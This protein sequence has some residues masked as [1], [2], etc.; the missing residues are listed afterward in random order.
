MLYRALRE[1]ARLALRWHYGEL[2]VQGTERIPAT[3][4]LLIVANHPNALVDAL[5][6]AITVRRRV[7]LTAK[8]TLFEHSVLAPLLRAVGVVPL[9][10]AKDERAAARGVAP[11]RNNDAFRLV[12][13]ALA[14][15]RAV[16][17]FPEGVSHDEPALAP[18][19]TGAARMAF[20]AR[21]S[22]T[23]GV[24]I[25]PV[26]LIFEEKERPR[27]RVLVRVGEPLDVD[28]WTHA[29][30]RESVAALTDEITERLRHVTLNFP[31]EDRARRA[32]RIARA[33]ATMADD[34]AS[35]A[36][37][38]SLATEALIAT[39]VEAVTTVLDAAPGAMTAR[40]DAFIA[41]LDLLEQRLA[42]RGANLLDAKISTRIRHGAR[43]VVREATLTAVAL[44]VAVLGWATHWL[45]IRFARAAAIRSLGGDASRDQPAMRTIIVGLAIVLVWYAAQAALVAWS[46]GGWVATAWIIIIYLAAQVQLLLAERFERARKRA[47]TYLV[48]RAD[49]TFRA[50]VLVEFQALL[51]EA[52]ALERAL[53][54]VSA[55]AL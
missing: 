21:E 2:I 33:L 25:L 14:R 38:S 7:W 41:R 19:R 12:T 4:P 11:S 18:L 22:G 42:A 45:P 29:E 37:A 44:P 5:V 39:R 49:P 24:H 8:A 35:L 36:I 52:I 32:V 34:P 6:V 3:G 54:G 55:S 26:G 47:R 30:P 53:L 15:G 51:N 27:S 43:F 13:E 50:Q 9:R 28:A 46:C 1:A 40:A 17:V 23:R 31:T 20:A 48:M 16:L 10:R